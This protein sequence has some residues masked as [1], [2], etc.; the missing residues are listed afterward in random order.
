MYSVCI[1]TYV[2]MCIYDTVGK[3]ASVYIST[4][5]VYYYTINTSHYIKVNFRQ[6]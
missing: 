2:C 4:S 5:N 6:T 3:S 1:Y